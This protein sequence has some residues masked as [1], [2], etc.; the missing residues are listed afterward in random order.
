[1]AH[2]VGPRV[3]PN[4]L[5]PVELRRRTADSQPVGRSF[6]RR[7]QNRNLVTDARS[8]ITTYIEGGASWQQRHLSMTSRTLA[9]HS[10][11][12]GCYSLASGHRQFFAS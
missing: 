9:A 7:E 8:R 11:P 2:T 12:A 3:A 4:S 10:A 1:M 5:A 6:G